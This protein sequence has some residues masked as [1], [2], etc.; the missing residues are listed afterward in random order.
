M[1]RD[2]K[3]RQLPIIMI[4]SRTADK[5]RDHALQLGVNAYMGKPYQEDELLEK[6]AQLL[7]SQSDK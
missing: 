7:V 4:T 2:E 3:T 6:I 5:H 1:R